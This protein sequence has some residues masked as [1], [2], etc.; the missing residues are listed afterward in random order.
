MLFVDKEQI[1]DDKI[2]LR[3]A[4]DVLVGKKNVFW[5][6]NLKLQADELLMLRFDS[7]FSEV[8]TS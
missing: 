3:Y 7:L 5:V 6:I 2:V 1:L 8:A 4:F